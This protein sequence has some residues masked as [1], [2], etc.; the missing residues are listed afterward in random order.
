[1][2]DSKLLKKYISE[3]MD[4]YESKQTWHL[5]HLVLTLVTVLWGFVWVFCWLSNKEA[6]TKAWDDIR[7]IV[8]DETVDTQDDF[9]ETT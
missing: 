5:L 8:N 2:N 1:M 9:E 6:Q 4:T 3:R 7:A